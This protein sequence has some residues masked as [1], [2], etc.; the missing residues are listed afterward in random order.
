MGGVISGCGGD[1][2][3]GSRGGIGSR[4]VDECE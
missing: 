4:E 3:G 2:R 1:G